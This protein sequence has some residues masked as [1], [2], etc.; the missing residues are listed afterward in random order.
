MAPL[1]NVVAAEHGTDTEACSSLEG[2]NPGDVRDGGSVAEDGELQC[3]R[4]T[5]VRADL[6]L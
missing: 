2:L 1:V 4:S 5:Y 3:V 6:M